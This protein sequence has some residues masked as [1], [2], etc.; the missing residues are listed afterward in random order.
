MAQLVLCNGLRTGNKCVCAAGVFGKKSVAGADPERTP[1][2]RV[3]HMTYIFKI[4]PY[5]E[6]SCLFSL[7]LSNYHQK[8]TTSN[9]DT[10]ILRYLESNCES[11]VVFSLTTE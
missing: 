1:V 9:C 7:E 8:A 10:Q 2:L 4:Y 5:T 6:V 3:H 11:H